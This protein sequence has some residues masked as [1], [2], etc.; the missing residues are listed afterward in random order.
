MKKKAK[1]IKNKK[2][3]VKKKNNKINYNDEKIIANKV[4]PLKLVYK[5]YGYNPNIEI[6]YKDININD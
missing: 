2:L 1:I 6:N 5:I 3:K 4:E